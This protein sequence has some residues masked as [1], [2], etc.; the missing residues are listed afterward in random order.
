MQRNLF[1]YTLLMIGLISCSLDSKLL[2][3]KEQKNKNDIKNDLDSI[4]KNTLNKL[5]DNQEEKKGLKNFEE[6]K[7]GGLIFPTPAESLES[8]R[9]TIEKENIGPVVSL[10][11]SNNKA[12]IPPTT[13]TISIEH[14]QKK[15]IKKEIKKE[16]LLP[17]TKEEKRADKEIKNIENAIR[18]S[19]FPKLIEDIRSL[20]HEYT[21]IKSDFYDVIDKINNKITLLMKNRHKNRTKITELRQLQNNLNTESEFDAIMTQIDIA[22]QDIGDAA[23]FFNEAKESLREGIIKRLENENRVALRLSKQALNKAEDAFSK[24]ENYSSKKNLAMGQSRII[25]KLIEQAKT[26]LSKS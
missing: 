13:T 6:L 17:S 12:S 10:E 9:P 8:T 7:D 14:N 26:A 19:G 24:L 15:E 25:K 23:L 2:G 21:S 4:Q 18:G 20:K 11:T 22:E 5:Y 16:Q 3:N 1:L